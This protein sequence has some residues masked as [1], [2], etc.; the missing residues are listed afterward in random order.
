MVAVYHQYRKAAKTAASQPQVIVQQAAVNP[1]E[2]LEKLAKLKE[3]GVLSEEEF[4][5]KK[6]ELLSKI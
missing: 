6:A 4:N 1:M 5:Q 2:Q 3:M